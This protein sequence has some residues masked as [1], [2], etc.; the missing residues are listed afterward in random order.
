MVVGMVNGMVVGMVMGLF[1]R[2]FGC[3]VVR[4]FGWL[5]LWMLCFGVPRTLG[6]FSEK[7][8]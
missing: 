2:L 7:G 3:G 8:W 5:F 6:K 1:V 4:L